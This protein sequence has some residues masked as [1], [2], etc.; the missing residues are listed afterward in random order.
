MSLL[1]NVDL[2]LKHSHLCVYLRFN[3]VEVA[4]GQEPITIRIPGRSADARRQNAGNKEPSNNLFDGDKWKCVDKR[5]LLGWWR[6]DVQDTK[7]W[8]QEGTMVV[9]ILRHIW[10]NR[11]LLSVICTMC[12]NERTKE[13]WR[14][15]VRWS[16]SQSVSLFAWLNL[17]IERQIWI[18]F[19]MDVMTLGFN[20]K[21]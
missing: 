18:Q 11:S 6:D 2:N 19:G 17:K 8:K 1:S 4:S 14:L 16:V 15:C 7:W 13:L 3:W 21:S 5:D 12:K 20:L 10:G 9:R